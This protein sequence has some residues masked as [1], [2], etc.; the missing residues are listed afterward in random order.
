MS[1]G[2]TVTECAC[3]LSGLPYRLQG[4]LIHFQYAASIKWNK[5]EA[6]ALQHLRVQLGSE[7][8]TVV[9]V[10]VVCV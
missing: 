10:C 7:S 3:D 8:E 5:T 2:H 6:G 9:S 1:I 4:H